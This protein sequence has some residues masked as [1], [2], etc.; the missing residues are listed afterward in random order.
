MGAQTIGVA[1]RQLDAALSQPQHRRNDSGAAIDCCNVQR[2][3]AHAVGCVDVRAG[4]QKSLDGRQTAG[5]RSQVEGPK[6]A[7][8]MEWAC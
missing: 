8:R 1:R 2:S 5:T 3:A 4:S 7:E 6:P